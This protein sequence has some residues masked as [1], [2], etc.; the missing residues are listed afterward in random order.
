MKV[1]Y[2]EI[3]VDVVECALHAGHRGVGEGWGEALV[4]SFEREE[5][6]LRGV[7]ESLKGSILYF[8][9]GVAIVEILANQDQKECGED[10]DRQKSIETLLLTWKQIDILPL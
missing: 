1:S 5:E 6:F 8:M 7:S 9:D 4:E 2:D 10:V 3:L